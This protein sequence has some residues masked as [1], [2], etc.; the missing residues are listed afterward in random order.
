MLF[1]TISFKNIILWESQIMEDEQ[2]L[3]ELSSAHKTS[4]IIRIK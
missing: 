1:S 3:A 2:T 4:E